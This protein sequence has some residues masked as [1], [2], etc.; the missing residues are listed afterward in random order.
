[1]TT[2]KDDKQ[3]EQESLWQ[4][5]PEHDY[6]V[7]LPP[8]ADRVKGG[9]A[10]LWQKLKPARKK[11]VNPLAEK[12]VLETLSDRFKQRVAPPPD[13]RSAALILEEA[14][15][16]R[17]NGSQHKPVVIVGPPHNNNGAMLN[18][19]AEHRGWRVITPPTTSQ[20][21]GQ[22]ESWL[23]TFINDTSPWIL[24]NLGKCYL[25]HYRGLT[26]LRQFLTLLQQPH[27][28]PPVI[29]CDSWAWAY[30]QRVMPELLPTAIT[31]QAFNAPHLERWLLELADSQSE[32]RPLRFF[33]SNNGDEVLP[34]PSSLEENGENAPPT[35]RFIK[36][37]AAYSRGIPGIAWSIWSNSLYSLPDK[38]INTSVKASVIERNDQDTIWVLPWE[39]IN[40]F[41]FPADLTMP[42]LLLA[43]NLLL[44]DGLDFESLTYVLPFSATEC[45]QALL[46]LTNIG[47]IEQSSDQWRVSAAAYSAIRQLLKGNDYLI[48]GL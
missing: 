45:G 30:F 11:P 8:M 15:A 18:H 23:Q 19:L 29:G 42:Q 39:Q 33:Q 41:S 9:L 46:A 38:N 22:D 47:L 31:L 5:V 3:T 28:E 13:W 37:L 16:N 20:I 17:N 12:D 1:M 4:F 2:Q 25:R 14:L 32:K 34:S 21:L 26:L 6:K 10:G 7:P 43:H 24:P 27:D 40:L 44:H 48:D 35:S 36:S